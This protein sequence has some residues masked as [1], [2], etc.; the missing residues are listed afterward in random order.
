MHLAKLSITKKA[1]LSIMILNPDVMLTI[2][3]AFTTIIF[4][5]NTNYLHAKYLYADSY[6]YVHHADY[7]FTNGHYAECHNYIHNDSCY[8][9]ECRNEVQHTDCH[10]TVSHLF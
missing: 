6:N 7:H 8:Y 9:A 5:H 2:I 1:L 10:F 4:N 3:F